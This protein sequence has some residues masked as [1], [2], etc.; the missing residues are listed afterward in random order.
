MVNIQCKE[1]RITSEKLIAL[2]CRAGTLGHSA[3]DIHET[4]IP[5]PLGPSPGF[6]IAALSTF[7]KLRICLRSIKEVANNLHLFS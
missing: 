3:D 7:K 4:L 1:K 2:A 6:K 5:V